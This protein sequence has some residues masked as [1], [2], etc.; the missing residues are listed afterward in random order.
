M[1]DVMQGVKEIKELIHGLEVVGVAVKKAMADGKISVADLPV[2]FGLFDQVGKLVEAVKGLDAVP[3]EVKDL[4][5]LEVQELL[6]EVLK[7]VGAIRAA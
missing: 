5:A 7:V 6:A 4:D 3:A 2:L 1:G